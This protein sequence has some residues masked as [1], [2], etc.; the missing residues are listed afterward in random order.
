MQE[1]GNTVSFFQINNLNILI[2][3]CKL[4]P[5]CRSDVQKPGRS[6][7]RRG[8][9]A[10]MKNAVACG[11]RGCFSRMLSVTAWTMCRI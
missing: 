2:S 6:E 11:S 3:V 8:N 10:T 4:I 7:Y 9:L 1:I 5:E